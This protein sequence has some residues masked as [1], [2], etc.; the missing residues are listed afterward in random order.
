MKSDWR[1]NRDDIIRTYGFVETIRMVRTAAK[2][3]GIAGADMRDMMVE[4]HKV[5]D[6]RPSYLRRGHAVDDMIWKE[7]E[8]LN[9]KQR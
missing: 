5:M 4:I 3:A 1:A 2:L 8:R 9:A 6:P 7:M